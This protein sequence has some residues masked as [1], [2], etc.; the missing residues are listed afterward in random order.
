[1]NPASKGV[2]A[3]DRS[4]IVS[5]E[6]AVRLIRDGDTIA[7][8]GF[9]GIGFAEEIAVALEALYLSKD[10]AH[11]RAADKPRN[12]TL[13]Y[14]AGQGDGK[15]RGLNHLGHEG[16]IGRVIGGTGDWCRT[17]R[18]SRFQTRSRP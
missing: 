13:V 5:A 8:G 7:T 14:A 15:N 2:A 3:A 18:S 12:L 10:E 11:V 9:V 16:L 6:E 17:C 4:K 1:M